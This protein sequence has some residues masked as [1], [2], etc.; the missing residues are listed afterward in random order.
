MALPTTIASVAIPSFD[1]YVGPFISSGGNVYTCLVDPG[2]V[3]NTIQIHK[4]TDPTSSFAEQDVANRPGTTDHIRALKV[5][6][7]G[8]DLH[9][10]HQ[11]NVTSR[12]G[13]SVFHMSTDFWDGTLVDEL[14]EIPNNA[15]VGVWSCAIALMDGKVV[16]LYTGDTDSVMGT[17]YNR[18]DYAIKNGTWSVGNAVDNAG[19]DHWYGSVIVPSNAAGHRVHFF[20]QNKNLNDAYQRTL[21][22][23]DTTPVLEIFPSA[24]DATVDPGSNHVF[25]SGISY[26]DG[27]T[28]RIRCPYRDSPAKV[29][30]AEFDSVDAPGAF[31]P[32]VDI[33][34]N[35]VYGFDAGP[36]ACLAVDGTDEHL[37]YSNNVDQ[38]LYHDK[39]KGIDVEIL[40]AVF[41]KHV[42]CNVYNRSGGTKL[43]YV[44]RDDATIKYNELDLAV[45]ASRTP[46]TNRY[47][48]LLAQ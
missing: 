26:D 28:Q 25:R 40:G 29:S 42:S 33:S 22:A 46:Y 47:Q 17:P 37:L 35:T 15:S 8:N 32:N 44:Y 19:E 20:F 14:I 16:V 43:A 41:I 9:I 3:S 45:A 23:I 39:N 36:V 7:D 10:V 30:Y 4:A 34:D 48:S 13:Y 6:Q 38:F 12:V 2:P 5:I 21:S 11:E 27:G 1:S 31:T 18:V 24:G